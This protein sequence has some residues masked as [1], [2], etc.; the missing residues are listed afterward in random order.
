[1][2]LLLLLHAAWAGTCTHGT[3]NAE[4]VSH[5]VKV[6]GEAFAREDRQS[7]EAAGRDLA[8]SVDCLRDPLNQ[9]EVVDLHV[10]RALWAYQNGGEA[11][12]APYLRAAHALTERSELLE[13]VTG[14]DHPLREAW[15]AAAPQNGPHPTRNMPP[16]ASGILVIDSRSKGDC[17]KDTPC[18][19]QMVNNLGQVASSDYLEPA[20]GLPPYP[21]LRTRLAIGG[22]AALLAS[23]A[24]L[25]VGALE[26]KS[27]RDDRAQCE[28]APSS[29]C[30][31]LAEPRNQVMFNNLSLIGGGVMMAGSVATFGVL[32]STYW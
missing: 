31:D 23:G 14:P 9:A 29:G 21:R 10:A 13:R 1:M 25:A 26:A 19:L 15:A 22:G 18:V 20:D 27:L 2:T 17:P 11:A 5:Y 30:N 8:W 12:A 6:A 28:A 16:A 24:L 3:V 4:Q 32:V 7:L